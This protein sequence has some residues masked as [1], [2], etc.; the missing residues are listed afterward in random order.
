MLVY[1]RVGLAWPEPSLPSCEFLGKTSSNH[2]HSGYCH[3]CVCYVARFSSERLPSPYNRERDAPSNHPTWLWVNIWNTQL[4]KSS[5]KT[6]QN[7]HVLPLFSHFCSNSIRV[8]E[9]RSPMALFFHHTQ[10][11]TRPPNPHAKRPPGVPAEDIAGFAFL[12]HFLW[13][14][15]HLDGATEQRIRRGWRY[16]WLESHGE[17]IATTTL[18]FVF[19]WRAKK[20]IWKRDS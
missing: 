18:V 3:D 11:A 13:A 1:Q 15:G 14:V 12:H 17:I 10:G 5:V 7:H 16:R 19:F 9:I 6:C 8:S 2:W 20:Y 4:P